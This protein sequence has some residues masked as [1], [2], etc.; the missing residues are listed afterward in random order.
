[1]YSTNWCTWLAMIVTLGRSE[2]LVEATGTCYALVLLRSSRALGTQRYLHDLCRSRCSYHLL[3][4]PLTDYMHD[5]VKIHVSAEMVLSTPH[6]HHV[7]LCIAVE[8]KSHAF[9]LV[10]SQYLFTSSPPQHCPSG[11]SVQSPSLY[12]LFRDAP[13][14]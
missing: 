1:M 14:Q 5:P 9:T 8:A 2:R 3:R 12:V 4:I 11:S 7:D 13:H 6:K 10:V